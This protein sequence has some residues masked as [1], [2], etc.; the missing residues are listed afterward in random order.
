MVDTASLQKYSLF[1]ALLPEEIEKIKPFLGRAEYRA[2]ETIISEGTANDRIYFI[3]E[4][5]VEVSKNGVSLLTI[6]EGE[7]FGEMELIDIMPSAA[8]IVATTHATCATISNRA[9][10]NIFHLDARIFG[11][12]ILNLARD[13]SRR[14]RRMDDLVVIQTRS[15]RGE[16][17][18]TCSSC[19][20]AET[21]ATEVLAAG[22]GGGA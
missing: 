16:A 11:I 12:I 7:T 5:C 17:C 1:G 14:L 13:L 19:P 3:L 22:F 2:G 8:T 9:I 18:T 10:H 21:G 20:D 15:G 6:G 4:G